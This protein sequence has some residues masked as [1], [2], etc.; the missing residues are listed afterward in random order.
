MVKRLRNAFLQ[1]VS[2]LMGRSQNAAV[3]TSGSGTIVTSDIYDVQIAYNNKYNANYAQPYGYY[4]IPTDSTPMAIT[5]LGVSGNSI[6]VLGAI[7]QSASDD[8]MGGLTE[9]E[10]GMKSFGDFATVVK[11]D[12]VG[13]LYNTLNATAC[14]GEDVQQILIDI[15]QQL[16]DLIT[17]ELAAIWTQ[18]NSHTHVQTGGPNTQ[19]MASSGTTISAPTINSVIVDDQ[20]FCESGKLL[21]DEN[22]VTPVR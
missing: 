1:A 22:G 8:I 14:S 12:S 5:N 2:I 16:Q 19:S 18:L 20:N 15:C 10:C 3:N 7:S 6:L 17:T 9:G 21:I 4:G 11:N 13:Y